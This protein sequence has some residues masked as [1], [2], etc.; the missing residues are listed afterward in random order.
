M[1]ENKKQ[2]FAASPRPKSSGSLYTKSIFK[3]N[4]YTKLANT[5][6]GVSASYKKIKSSFNNVANP[7]G[8]NNNLLSIVAAAISDTEMSELATTATNSFILDTSLL[9]INT[10][11]SKDIINCV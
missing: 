4:R 10:S 11:V 2:K 7:T 3:G 8:I 6:D 5:N 9:I 1:D